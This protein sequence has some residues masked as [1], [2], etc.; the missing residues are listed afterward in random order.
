[1]PD[2]ENQQ[3]ETLREPTCPYCGG[4]MKQIVYQ[5]SG[6][7]TALY[8][9]RICAAQSPRVMSSDRSHAEG[10]A[11]DQAF[12]RPVQRPMTLEEATGLLKLRREDGRRRGK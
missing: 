8:G 7:Y 2:M 5:C 12:S 1:M 6:V 4:K 9:C 3:S 11:L 10:R